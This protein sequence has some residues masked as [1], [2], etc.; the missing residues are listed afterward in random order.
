MEATAA[1]QH[2]L[3]VPVC[4]MPGQFPPST[5]ELR[6]M[7][8]QQ[9]YAAG[10]NS[11]GGIRPLYVET[12]NVT[13]GPYRVSIV[14][15]VSHPPRNLP[16]VERDEGSPSAP[17]SRG[18]TVGLEEWQVGME[19]THPRRTVQ[20]RVGKAARKAGGGLKGCAGGTAGDEACQSVRRDGTHHFPWPPDK[21]ADGSAGLGTSGCARQQIGQERE[22]TVVFRSTILPDAKCRRGPHR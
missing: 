1:R 17:A 10:L 21:S 13:A 5:L 11:S 3:V 4:G 9:T 14:Q 2:T 18:Q 7:L 12:D 6:P 19:K 8:R 15:W 16:G 20:K 22:H